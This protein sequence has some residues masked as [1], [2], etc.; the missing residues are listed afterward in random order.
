MCAY[1]IISDRSKLERRLADVDLIDLNVRSDNDAA[2]RAY[3]KV[4]FEVA[5]K[6]DEWM[7]EG[8]R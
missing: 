6:Y 5:G 3:C 1:S 4:G 8:R 2:I 7:M